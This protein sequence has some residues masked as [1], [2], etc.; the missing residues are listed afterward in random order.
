MNRNGKWMKHEAIRLTQDRRCEIIA[1]LSKP[2]A[3]SK[4][5]LFDGANNEEYCVVMLE[6]FMKFWKR[7]ELKKDHL[8]MTKSN[9]SR[10]LLNLI[11]LQ[12]SK[13]L[14]L[15]TTLSSTSTTN[16]FAPM[17]KRKLNK[18]MTNCNDCLRR[19]NETL[20]NWH[21]IKCKKFIH[22]RQTTL[23]DMFK[24]YSTDHDFCQK[25]CALNRDA[26]LSVRIL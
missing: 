20:T 9:L 23:H 22:S 4:R 3:P 18:Y 21:W 10:H 15:Y 2:N 6:A 11:V 1:K 25:N 13:V 19:F 16:C 14:K 12:T 24:Q 26:Y 17:F 5:A 8:L 7:C